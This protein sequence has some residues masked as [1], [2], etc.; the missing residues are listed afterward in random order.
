MLL[1]HSQAATHSAGGSRAEAS[2]AMEERC[3]VLSQTVRKAEAGWRKTIS[4]VLCISPAVENTIQSK[5]PPPQHLCQQRGSMVSSSSSSSSSPPP[6]SV[7]DDYLE[8]M[9]K[10]RLKE[11]CWIGFDQ[12][13]VLTKQKSDKSNQ[14]RFRLLLHFTMN[15]STNPALG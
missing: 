8:A 14:P 13:S 7:E 2:A 5:L 3:A 15:C 11:A 4:D 10:A 1:K 9:A 12:L 6:C